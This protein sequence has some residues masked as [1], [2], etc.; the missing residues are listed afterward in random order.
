VS[1]RGHSW[2]F[3]LAVTLVAVIALVLLLTYTIGARST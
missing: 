2:L 1:F 3:W